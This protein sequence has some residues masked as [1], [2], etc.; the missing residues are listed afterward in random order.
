MVQYSGLGKSEFPL[1]SRAKVEPL[2]CS[3][4]SHPFSPKALVLIHS[5]GWLPLPRSPLL[6]TSLP[7]ADSLSCQT[8]PGSLLKLPGMT[9]QEK[10][11]CVSLQEIPYIYLDLLKVINLIVF[12]NL[13]PEWLTP[14]LLHT[15]RGK[16]QTYSASSLSSNPVPLLCD[17]RQV[18][19]FLDSHF[20]FIYKAAMI[21]APT[22]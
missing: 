2:N 20:I 16:R 4:G 19:N 22:S 3:Q 1:I 13:T 5:S 7:D 15:N 17:L 6:L 12:Y 9:G 14:S 11:S 10:N 8:K 18:L 21:I